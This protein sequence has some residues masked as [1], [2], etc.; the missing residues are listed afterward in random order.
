MHMYVWRVWEGSIEL[1]NEAITMQGS[2]RFG[3]RTC[4]GL[5]DLWAEEGGHVLYLPWL[6]ST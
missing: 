1:V 5:W 4:L 3:G 2:Q 6:Y